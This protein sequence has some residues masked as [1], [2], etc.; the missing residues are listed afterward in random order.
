MQ[1]A[2][3]PSPLT[4][5][6]LV[7]TLWSPHNHLSLSD[8]DCQQLRPALVLW[9]ELC[10]LENKL[11]RLFRAAT[12]L[13]RNEKAL[14]ILRKHSEKANDTLARNQ[15]LDFAFNSAIIQDQNLTP[16]KRV[17]L[18]LAQNETLALNSAIKKDIK[19]E[20]LVTRVWSASEHPQ[21]VAFEMEG[22]LQI[23][24]AQYAIAQAVIDNPGAVVQLNMGLGKTR[25][26]VPMLVLHWRFSGE[27]VRLN[28]LSS[29]LPEAFAFLH[30]HLTASLFGVKLFQIPFHRN[31]EVTP[32]RV[33]SLNHQA[34][35]C[36][37]DAGALVMTPEARC[38][39][40]L[41]QHE[42]LIAGKESDRHGLA[43]F[44]AIPC[45]HIIDE[46]DE[47]LH[48]KFQLVYAVGGAT[49]LPSLDERCVALRAVMHALQQ[50]PAVLSILSNERVAVC[51]TGE[52]GA[53]FKLLRL[54]P[55]E[56]LEKVILFLKLSRLAASIQTGR[57]CQMIWQRHYHLTVVNTII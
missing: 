46:S 31:V 37:G 57:R 53:F 35:Y 48:V 17:I 18:T 34:A 54:L 19:S 7:Q 27:T 12:S 36:L 50:S 10:V 16:S 5:F 49:K 25:V 39:L 22:A 28:F 51:D 14:L 20:L 13:S 2:L 6:F 41:K 8:D 21:W 45:K 23:R 38:S 32:E 15:M 3:H 4:E 43:E 44:E 47:V 56:H 29:L 30:E 52:P 40:H 1:V 26:T 11:E 9:L 55:G 24:P 42:L 33:A